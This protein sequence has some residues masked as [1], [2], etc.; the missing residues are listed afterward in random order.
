MSRIE[1]TRR[2]GLRRVVA[3]TAVAFLGASLLAA[4]AAPARA[5][6]QKPTLGR[7]V[8][9][10]ND[11]I[12]VIVLTPVVVST[13]SSA[14]PPGPLAVDGRLHLVLQTAYDAG[15][16]VVERR[17]HA[18]LMNAFVTSLDGSF[19]VPATGGGT[20]VRPAQACT[21]DGCPSDVWT[22]RFEVPQG[23]SFALRLATRYD[24][25]GTPVAVSVLRPVLG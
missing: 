15:G 24:S 14:G 20:E 10:S 22:V 9:G 1:V 17:L 4:A 5:D 12:I 11:D 25:D 7:K 2:A 21:D 16:Q 6:D 19:R 3:G 18:N 23:G 13:Y 8:H